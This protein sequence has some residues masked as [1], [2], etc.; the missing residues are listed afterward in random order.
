MATQRV[1]K[2]TVEFLKRRIHGG[3]EVGGGAVVERFYLHVVS[4]L[5]CLML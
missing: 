2:D 5:H 1:K 4:E 3:V